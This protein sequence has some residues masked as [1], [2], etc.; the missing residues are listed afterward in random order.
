M[1]KTVATLSVILITIVQQDHVHSQA[2]FAH[3]VILVDGRVILET[4]LTP[5]RLIDEVEE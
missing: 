3:I 1:S 4:P 2:A 5:Q